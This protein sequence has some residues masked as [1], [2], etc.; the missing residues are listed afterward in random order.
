MVDFPSP[1][2]FKNK[3][4]KKTTLSEEIRKMHRILFIT[5]IAINI[6][7][8]ALLLYV[9][10]QQ[11]TRGY[12]LK[13]LQLQNS[14]ILKENKYLET[15][16]IEAKSNE[17]VQRSEKLETMENLIEM[18]KTGQEKVSYMQEQSGI[19]KKESAVRQ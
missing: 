5:V 19:A 18:K 6:T 7:L 15:K 11:T 8:G 1:S 17:K 13:K 14:E 2:H 16:I 12:T 4:A 3:R 9:G 10:G